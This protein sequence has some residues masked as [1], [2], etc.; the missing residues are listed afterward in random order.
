MAEADVNPRRAAVFRRAQWTLLVLLSL[1]VAVH[2]VV[3]WNTGWS[4]WRLGGLGMYTEP[5]GRR[6]WAAALVECRTAGCRSELRDAKALALRVESF[7]L[8]RHQ[9]DGEYES[10]EIDEMDTPGDVSETL[11]SF[12]TFPSDDNA[13]RLVRATIERPCAPYLAVRYRQRVSLISRRAYVDA[14][15]FVV[16]ATEAGCP[17]SG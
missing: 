16:S 3:I 8:L 14:R 13:R 7:D 11:R 15:P 6:Y 12:Y 17:G 2:T 9:P 10:V 1:W 5:S 4:A